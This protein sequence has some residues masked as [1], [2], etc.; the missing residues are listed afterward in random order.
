MEIK[1]GLISADS[2]AIL[3]RDAYTERM[4]RERW[5]DLVFATEI[6]T[7]SKSL[8]AASVGVP[9]S[10]IVGGSRAADLYGT[11]AV[12]VLERD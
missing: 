11:L 9:V 10:D 4:S 2:H 1:F 3:E 5:G 12:E 6:G 7:N 8:E